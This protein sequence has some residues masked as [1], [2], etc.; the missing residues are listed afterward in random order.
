MER[1]LDTAT[2][3]KLRA[4]SFCDDATICRWW[5]DRRCVRG[6]TDARLTR[7]AHEGGI[8]HPDERVEAEDAP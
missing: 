2:R 5:F 1:D 7:A 6:A 3:L 8:L 4:L